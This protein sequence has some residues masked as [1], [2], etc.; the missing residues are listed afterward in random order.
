MMSRLTSPG[1][2]VADRFDL[3]P[4]SNAAAITISDEADRDA[5]IRLGEAFMAARRSSG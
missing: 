2:G 3:V 5:T 1:V 4:S